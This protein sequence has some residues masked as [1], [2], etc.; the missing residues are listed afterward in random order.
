MQPPWTRHYNQG[1]PSTCTYPNYTLPDL[2]RSA[3]TRFPDSPA[4]LFYGTSITFSK[5]DQ[6]I[7]RFAMSLQKIGVRQGDRVAIMLPNIPQAI[8]AYY[9]VLAAGATVVQTN[10]LYLEAELETQLRDSGA[11][12]ILTLDLF[13]PRI[14]HIEPRTPLRRIIVTSVKDYLPLGKRVLYLIKTKV[15]G[16]SASIPKRPSLYDF[17]EMLSP[18]LAVSDYARPS[19]SPEDLALLQYT[20]GTT[21]TPKGVMLSHQNIL[22]NTLQCRAWVPDFQEGREVFLGVIPF[23]HVYGLSTCQHLA[24]VTGSTLVLL[25]RFQVTEVLEAIQ[26]HQVTIFSAI[27]MM[28]MKITEFPKIQRYNLRSLRVCL[29]GASPLHAEVQDRFERLTGVRISEGYGLT[30]AGPVT[31]CT[32][33]YGHH[34]RG[35]IGVPF[36]DTEARIVDLETGEHVMPVGQIGELILRGPQIMQGYWNNERETRQVLRNGWLYSG[37]IARQDETGFFYLIDRKKDMIKTRG[38]NVYPREV[39]EVLFRHSAVKDVVVAGVPDH[40]LGEAVKAYVVLHHGQVIS[41]SELIT[42]CRQCLAA[43]K[44]PSSIAFRQEL[45]RTL[46]GKALR[47]ALQSEETSKVDSEQRHLGPGE[48]L[49]GNRERRRLGAARAGG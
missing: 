13:Y 30:E 22:A 31:H 4:L 1:V 8:I 7:H 44:V 42:H 26:E 21:G 47:R 18:S 15:S 19:L 37:D 35:S 48:R 45:P 39:E 41:E 11:E 5:L 32:P 12:T 3:A 23:F 34:P 25:P 14:K 36:P 33:V 24:M 38:E 40:R 6:C 9:G 16:R 49:A 46:V 29:S 2:L 27:P 43:F 28:F 17:R 10:P 20:G